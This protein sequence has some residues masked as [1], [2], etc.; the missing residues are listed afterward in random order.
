MDVALASFPRSQI[1]LQVR[2][3]GDKILSAQRS[4]SQVGMQDDPGGVDDRPQGRAGE[5]IQGIPNLRLQRKRFRSGPKSSPGLIEGAPDLVGDQAPGKPI[6]QRGEARQ[7]LIY[8]GELAQ[9]FGFSQ[10]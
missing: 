2:V 9:L 1:V 4:A 8:R 3:T 6:L 7:S 5:P 10:I